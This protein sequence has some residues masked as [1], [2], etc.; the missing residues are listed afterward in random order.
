[1]A[2]EAAFSNLR[3][4]LNAYE[5]AVVERTRPG[6]LASRRA[7]LDAHDWGKIDDKSPLLTRRAMKLDIEYDC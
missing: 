2:S 4:A 7:C 3:A 6:V 5:K 1:M